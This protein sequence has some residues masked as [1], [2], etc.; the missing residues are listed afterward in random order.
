MAPRTYGQFCPVAHALDEIGDRWTLLILRD[1]SF[2]PQRFT[3]LRSSLSGLATNLLILR[4]RGLEASGLVARVELPAPA[5]RTVYELTEAGRAVGPVLTALARFGATR[6]PAPNPKTE[7]R[8][9]AA[10]VAALAAFH[11]PEAG[12]D[13]QEEYRVVVDGE[14]FD[15]RASDGRHLPARTTAE[16]KATITSTARTLLAIRRGERTFDGCVASGDIT[17]SGNQRSI[18]S[19]RRVFAL[20]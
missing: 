11:R 1:L 12:V 20:G 9:R 13:Q 4:L 14:A 2:G 6:L 19:F 15:L 3:D 17:A 7:V 8:P 10:V 18:R 5:A 16:P